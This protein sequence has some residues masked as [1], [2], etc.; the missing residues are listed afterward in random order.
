MPSLSGRPGL[1]AV[2]R[3]AGDAAEI[4]VAGG[5][6]HLD[7]VAPAL[8]VRPAVEFLEAGVEDAHRDLVGVVVVVAVLVGLVQQ[9]LA[10]GLVACE[11]AVQDAEP[12]RPGQMAVP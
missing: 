11:V 2:G 12:G 5:G 3:R 6:Q 7:A 1:A 9:A 4:D 10:E 8:R